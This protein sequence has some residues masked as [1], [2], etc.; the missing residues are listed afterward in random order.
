MVDSKKKTFFII[1]P[2]SAGGS[3]MRKWPI[4]CEKLERLIGEFDYEFTNAEGVAT[5]LAYE[6]VKKGY[7]QIVSVGGDGTLHEILQGIFDKGVLINP[8]IALGALPIG[9]YT[10]F[11]RSL[12][13]SNDLDEAINRMASNKTINI[14]IGKAS[15]IN[16]NGK[17]ESRYFINMGEVGL[18]GSVADKANHYPKVFGTF[19]TYL[20][21]SI[22][23]FSSYKSKKIKVLV[24][25]NQNAGCIEDNVVSVFVANG[26]YFG[27]GMLVAPDANV[28]D[29]LFD[30]IVVNSMSKWEL[31][32]A[33]PKLY[34]GKLSKLSGVKSF[35]AKNIKIESAE[36][37]LVNL[38]GEQPGIISVEFN[39]LPKAI[40]FIV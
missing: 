27:G 19:V 9:A 15:Y 26:K 28:K 31:L 11:T 7:N 5:L 12:N 38:D 21:S 18:G 10:D 30:V 39:L 34:S 6:A 35:K 29:G 32:G 25:G 37:V 33:L 17:K 22:L 13:F 23:A 16:H 8:E 20:V 1:N 3:T 2:N 40:R 14:D 36:E 24:D 4:T